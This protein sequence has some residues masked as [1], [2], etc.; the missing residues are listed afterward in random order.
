MTSLV[1][2]SIVIIGFLVVGY[3]Y[4]LGEYQIYYWLAAGLVAKENWLALGVYSLVYLA[5]LVSIFICSLLSNTFV[6]VTFGLMFIFNIAFI[7]TYAEI[8]GLSSEDWLDFLLGN[9]IHIFDLLRLEHGWALDFLRSYKTEFVYAVLILVPVATVVCAPPSERFS[10]KRWW[11]CVPIISLAAACIVAAYTKGNLNKFS[12]AATLPAKVG[13][14]ILFRDTDPPAE[15]A[16]VEWAPSEPAFRKIVFIMDESIRGDFTTLGTPAIDT[17]PYLASF[18]PDL[19]NFGVAASAHN[20]SAG[21]RYIFRY[22]IRPEELPHAIRRG[23]NA[24][25]PNIWQYAKKAGLRTVHIDAFRGMY[26]LHSGMTL[27]EYGMI[28]QRIAVEAEPKY[29]MDSV[30]ARRVI[31]ALADPAPSFIYVEKY[32]SH[33][34]Y[35]DKYPS[36]QEWFPIN[37]QEDGPG[38]IILF[39]KNAIRWTVDDFFR[40]LLDKA[41]LSDVLIIYTSD[42]GQTLGDSEYRI[43]HCTTERPSRDE[44]LVPLFTITS[45]QS[46]TTRL[47]D[48]AKQRADRST[49]FDIFPTLLMALGYD[50][51]TVRAKYG[52]SLFDRPTQ[53]RRFLVG[54]PYNPKFRWIDVDNFP[55]SEISGN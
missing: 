44:G 37:N 17:T 53:A 50:E 39:Y 54:L 47:K 23:F 38:S 12:I 32:G 5:L 42:H 2:K 10:L 55:L 52:P 34:P 30:V 27:L 45:H 9:Y 49:H 29:L 26:G 11:N 48:A 8:V 24:E 16:V 19:A 7:L 15:P 28:D 43:S 14:E 25:G 41:D 3:S 31:E 20:C 6:R 51:Q 21:S 13:L 1:A 33:A 4:L 36:E 35:D 22:G 46:W 18:G 40:T